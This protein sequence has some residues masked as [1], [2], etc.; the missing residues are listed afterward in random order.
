MLYKLRVNFK[1]D[2]DRKGYGGVDTKISLVRYIVSYSLNVGVSRLVLVFHPR[3]IY[4][5]THSYMFLHTRSY[6][7]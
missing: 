5:N 2:I 4:S 6:V 7:K 3:C 1:V